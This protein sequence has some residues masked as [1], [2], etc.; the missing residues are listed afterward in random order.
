MTLVVVVLVLLELLFFRPI[1]FKVNEFNIDIV[2][3]HA[4][5]PDYV[6]FILF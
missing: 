6:G 2:L 5:S 3:R 4:L 1:F